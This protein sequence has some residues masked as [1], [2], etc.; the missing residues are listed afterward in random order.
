M[1][2]Y[3]VLG[4]ARGASAAEIKRA[5]RRLARRLHPD[6]NP[7]DGEAAERFKQV[8]EAYDTLTDP[9][10]RRRYDAG[11]AND[12]AA[13]S[14][15][16]GFSGFDFSTPGVERSTTFG[17]LFEDV[18]A[19]LSARQRAGEAERGADI[20]LKTSLSF[21]QALRGLEWPGIVT[22]HVTCRACG[23]TG[24]NRTIETRCSMCEGHGAVRSVRGHMVFSKTCPECG[25]TGR[26]RRQTCDVCSGQGV[27]MQTE[28]LTI[29]I[30]PGVGTGARVRVPG[31]GHAGVRGGAPGDLFVEIDVCADATF[32]RVGDDLQ[33][34]V[35]IAIHEAAL[36]ARIEIESPDGPVWLRVPP[37]T[38][39]GQRFRL[40]GRGAPSVRSGAR[41]DLLVEVRLMLP[42]LLDERSKELLREFGRINGDS[43]RPGPPGGEPGPDRASSARVGGEAGTTNTA[44]SDA[45]PQAP[46]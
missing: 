4:L 31:K 22:R 32:Q 15:A 8:S 21:H 35:P 37:G 33:V 18:F 24:A 9:E 13:G 10:R 40:R 16:F 23:G 1:D 6:I 46:R 27:E 29:R 39:S 14:G 34:V 20:H 38:Q 25:G 44:A 36:G 43:V 19:R 41:G 3:I 7:G 2:L 45:E 42:P 28:S 12:P 30:P 11:A 26:L 5:Y 17:E